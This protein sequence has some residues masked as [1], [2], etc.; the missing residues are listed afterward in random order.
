MPDEKQGPG[1]VTRPR[2]GHPVSRLS[3]T[4]E[5]L[6]GNAVQDLEAGVQFQGLAAALAHEAH[7]HGAAGRLGAFHA[8]SGFEEATSRLPGRGYQPLCLRETEAPGRTGFGAARV[9]GQGRSQ[10]PE[11]AAERLG[12][13]TLLSKTPFTRRFS[14][15]DPGPRYRGGAGASGTPRREASRSA[16]VQAPAL[17]GVAEDFRSGPDVTSPRPEAGPGH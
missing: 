16:I 3:L 10:G 8:C 13:L 2:P 14:P 15:G 12:D 9:P 4:C 17:P 1:E 7:L 6:D 11:R 5:L